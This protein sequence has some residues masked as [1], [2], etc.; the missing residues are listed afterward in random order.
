MGEQV[1][2]RQLARGRDQLDAGQHFGAGRRFGHRLLPA[3]GRDRYAR[4]GEAWDKAA[5]LVVEREA[6]GL[7]HHQ[8]GD[9][10]DRLARRHHPEQIVLAHRLL[11]LDVADA[12]RL[13]PHQLV[14]T[15]DHRHRA[16]NGMVVDVLLDRGANALQPGL[17]HSDFLRPVQTPVEM[18]IARGAGQGWGY[19]RCR[20]KADASGKSAA[21]R[22]RSER[23]CSY[24][25]SMR[26]SSRKIPTISALHID[27][28]S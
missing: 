2:D 3:F 26:D 21:T 28:F 20:G 9:R 27:R 15:C 24:P 17:R 8:H 25:L 22:D 18:R 10:G 12:L 7:E 6:A 4:V 19:R 14:V 11:R 5:D 23:H 1:L 13:I 16:G